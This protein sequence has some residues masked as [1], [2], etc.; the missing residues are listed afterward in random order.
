[1]GPNSD[2]LPSEQNLHKNKVNERKIANQLANKKKKLT[3]KFSDKFGKKDFFKN[4]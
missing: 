4:F 2:K 1:M 3:S